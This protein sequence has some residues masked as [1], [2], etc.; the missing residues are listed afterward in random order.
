MLARKDVQAQ[1]RDVLPAHITPEKLAALTLT[2]IRS[3]PKLL[4]C[5]QT[6]L[7]GAVLESSKLGLEIATMGQCWVVPYGKEAT[8]LVG[9]RGMVSLAYRS[10]M[11]ADAE[12]KA[13][14]E[15][16]SFGYMFGTS[17]FITHEP[18][19]DADRSNLTYVYA[20]IH[21]TTGGMLFD[22]MTKEDIEKI[23]NRSR[24]K[25]SG[26]WTTDYAEMAKKTVLRRLLKMAPCSTELSRA[27]TLDEQA[28]IGVSQG[29][30]DAI[31]VTPQ[32][33]PE[34]PE[35]ANVPDGENEE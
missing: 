4:D 20:I 26:P 22:V 31:D 1:I 14:Y 11:I 21:T 15:G 3:T 10:G 35:A 2:Q 29:L 33:E 30:G 18:R 24:A 17:R 27:V 28:E 5:T 7:L 6:S 9:Y 16:D 19:A 25:S 23:R 12:A 34:V 8:L 32:E 13:V